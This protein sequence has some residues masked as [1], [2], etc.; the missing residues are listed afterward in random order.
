MRKKSKSATPQFLSGSFLELF[1]LQNLF[2][3]LVLWV[4]F[5]GG[6][7]HV[8]TFS[9]NGKNKR[10]LIR[11]RTLQQ[12]VAFLLFNK[13]PSQDLDSV[14]PGKCCIMKKNE[15]LFHVF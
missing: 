2:S 7:K 15:K 8:W 5:A 9:N 6:K 14:C 1:L 13:I 12:F 3:P 11:R 4:L 10:K